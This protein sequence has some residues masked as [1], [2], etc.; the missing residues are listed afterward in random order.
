MRRRRASRI[1]VA[2]AIGALALSL[3]AAPAA[4]QTED[5][6]ESDAPTCDIESPQLVPETPPAI[7]GLGFD[8]AWAITRGAGV[9]V[10]VVG[11]GI[12]Q[13]N[14]HFPG[15]TVLSGVNLVREADPATVAGDGR[16]AAR[17]GVGGARGRGG[18]GVVGAAPEVTLVPVRVGYGGEARSQEDVDVTPSRLAAGIRAAADS[19]AQVIAVGMATTQDTA[20][21]RS[22]VTEA[23]AGGA[24]V[25]ATVGG[26]QDAER[27]A[28]WDEESGASPADPD[29]PWYPAAYPEVLAVA[30]VTEDGAASGP[31]GSWVDVA[32]PGQAVPTTFRDALDCVLGA[33]P[34]PTYATGYAAATAALVA[35]EFP[36]S[37]PAE[38]AYRI[39]ATAS[40]AVTDSRD[41]ATG[42]GVVNPFEALTLYV[43]GSAPGPT[44]PPSIVDRQEAPEVPAAEVDLSRPVDPDAAARER[45]VWW[46]LGG[47]T[48]VG[49]L[50]LVPRL[51]RRTGR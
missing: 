43:D 3:G 32:A 13:A 46:L 35:A 16:G 40:G 10:A 47:L 20:A 51:P 9:D 34:D 7:A 33:D 21:L 15:K 28:A 39:E 5:E 50:L 44:P 30:A 14:D 48:A 17:A 22:A 2:W 11:T 27:Q 38:W 36:D 31:R 12:S 6:S 37:S 25:V 49:L 19:G 45:L 18:S 24:L 8:R 42:W 1:A 29:A 41:D 4:A 23:T 26:A